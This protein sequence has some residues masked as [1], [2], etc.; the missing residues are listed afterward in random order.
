MLSPNDLF[1]PNFTYYLTGIIIIGHSLT[2]I[3][4]IRY[5][6]LYT[7]YYSVYSASQYYLRSLITRIT[8]SIIHPLKFSFNDKNTEDLKCD[9]NDEFI[10]LSERINNSL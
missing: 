6:V 1:N 8:S 2:R 4:F 5:S 7:L 3:Y 10:L 9:G